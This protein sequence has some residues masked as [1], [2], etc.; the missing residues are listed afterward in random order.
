MRQVNSYLAQDDIDIYLASGESVT[1]CL[2]CYIFNT[3]KRL[4][5]SP[6]LLV[7]QA[8]SRLW[9]YKMYA[10]KQEKRLAR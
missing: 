3:F 6:A 9:R 1:K 2:C 5:K 4:K 7:N 10:G 8:K